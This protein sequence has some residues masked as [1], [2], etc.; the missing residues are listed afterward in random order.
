M[1][2]ICSALCEGKN[3]WEATK[4]RD[5]SDLAYEYLRPLYRSLLA[6]KSSQ[7]DDDSDDDGTT[8]D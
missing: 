8:G 4:R 6:E 3:I 7:V 5:L 1:L 2:R